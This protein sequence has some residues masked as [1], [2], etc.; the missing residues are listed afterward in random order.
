MNIF[1]EKKK[2]Q[3][4]QQLYIENLKIRYLYNLY[5]IFKRE[6]TVKQTGETNNRVSGKPKYRYHTYVCFIRN[7]FFVLYF[8][9][10][11]D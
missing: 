10:K 4:K 2:K 6:Y 9:F 1:S 3:K 8:F 11:S 7:T 5:N